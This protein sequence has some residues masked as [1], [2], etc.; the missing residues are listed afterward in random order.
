MISFVNT[1]SKMYAQGRLLLK[2]KNA[3][4]LYV[5]IYCG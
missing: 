5:K 3:I 2:I 1:I 4:V